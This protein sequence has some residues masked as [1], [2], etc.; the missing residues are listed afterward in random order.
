MILTEL[1]WRVYGWVWWRLPGRTERWRAML[2]EA[3]RTNHYSRGV[4]AVFN[5]EWIEKLENEGK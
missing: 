1:F 2:D 3:L 4:K 5:K